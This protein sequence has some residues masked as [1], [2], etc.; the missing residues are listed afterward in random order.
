MQ[1]T[2]KTKLYWTPHPSLS[3]VPCFLF[4]EK[5]QSSLEMAASFVI[6]AIETKPDVLKMMDRA[7]E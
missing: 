7:T 1:A 2:V 6:E 5:L 3:R 4:N